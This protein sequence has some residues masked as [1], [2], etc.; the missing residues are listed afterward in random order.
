MLSM[1]ARRNMLL[2]LDAGD[3]SSDAGYQYVDEEEDEVLSRRRRRHGGGDVRNL[4]QR[5]VRARLV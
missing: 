1:R 5:R 4:M 2:E 3:S